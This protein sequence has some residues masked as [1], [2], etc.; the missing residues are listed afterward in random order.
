MIKPSVYKLG[1]QP[2]YLKPDPGAGAWNSKTAT[3]EMK[4]LKEAL[5]NSI[6]QGLAAH[7]GGQD[8]VDHIQ[9]YLGNSGSTLT[10]K[11][12]K[13][14]N[15]V[16]LA[17]QAHDAQV[18]AAKKFIES[19]PPGTHQFTSDTGSLNH[20]IG[21]ADSVNWF[22]A[23][24]SYTTWGAGT[25][26]ITPIG[27]GKVKYG[28]DYE[29][30]FFDRYNWDGGKHVTIPI[31]GYAKLP[32]IVQD[33]IDKLPNVNNGQL[34]VTDHFM[35]EFHRMGLAKEFDMVATIKTHID[36]QPAGGFIVY[37]VKPGDSLSKIAKTY[38]G[39]MNWNLIHMANKPKIPNPNLI[40][41]GMELRIPV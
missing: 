32:K 13:M 17:K 27:P 2:P 18:E 16:K 28:M 8:A 41:A 26:K 35:G 1:T 23:V 29:L 3:L 14:I 7:F 9:H 38:Y 5:Q 24:G 20:A 33:Q 31:P 4:A 11:F 19:L 36:W 15:E 39:D 30:H 34:K 25:A 12:Q 21:K 6:T 22:F 37:K 40:Q 10:I